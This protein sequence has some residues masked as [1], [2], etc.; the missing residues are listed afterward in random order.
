MHSLGIDL[1]TDPKKV[2][3]CQIDWDQSP[4]RVVSLER[5][6]DLPDPRLEGSELDER[7]LVRDQHGLVAALVERLVAFAPGEGRVV[8]IDAPFG[9]PVAFVEAVSNWE[10]GDLQGFRKRPELRLRATDRFVQATSGVTPLSVSVDRIGST[11]M[12]CVEVLSRYA[13]R[14]DAPKIDRARALSGVAEVYPAAALRLWT[15]DDGRQL[16]AASYKTSAPAREELLL[17]VAGIL[18][19]ELGGEVEQLPGY[20]EAGV[21]IPV[22]LRAPMLHHDDAFDAFLCALVARAVALGTCLTI[23]RDV[24]A[25][26]LYLRT[27]A[28]LDLP[29]THDRVQR[30]RQLQLEA[31]A[32]ADA[33]GWV[34]IPAAGTIRASLGLEPGQVMP[35]AGSA[36]PADAVL[37][38]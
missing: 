37:A 8:G 20:G 36:E 5:L 6:T 21:C 23:D 9:W 35:G 22:E 12:L 14:L 18:Q 28:A 3:L 13:R 1:S 34:H 16:Q 30:A 32:A 11:A 15:A 4:P 7:P 29:A 25:A 19:D 24:H 38:A 33:E 17:Q 31:Q 2:W 26:Q 10:A 27:P